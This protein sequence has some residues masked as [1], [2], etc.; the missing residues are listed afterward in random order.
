MALDVAVNTF[1]CKKLQPFRRPDQAME[2]AVNIAPSTTLSMGQVLAEVAASVNDVQTLTVTGTP[3][4]G[5]MVVTATNPVGGQVVTFTVAYNSTNA[6]AQTAARA[7]LGN[8]ITVT[9]GALP[10]T[11]LVFTASGAFVGLPMAPMTV[12]AAGLTGGT[13]PAASFAHTTQGATAGTFAAY[14]SAV[15][16]PPAAPTVAGN[17]SGSSYAA[18]TYAVQVTFL[19]ASGE[20]TPSPVTNVTVTAAQNLRVSAYSSVA[21]GITGANFYVNGTWEATTA[22]SSGNIPQT[23]L[24]GAAIGTGQE[25]PS[26]NT[27]YTAASGLQTARGLLAYDVATDSAGMITLGTSSTGGPF[28]QKT[29]NVSM[30]TKGAFWTGDL[31]GI[32]AKA[33]SDLGKLVSGTTSAGELHIA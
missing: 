8:N 5:S 2:E 6:Q 16:A 31:V 30:Y 20:T 7:V 9:G 19:T 18:G 17:G 32:D 3:T 1:T 24:T 12:N 29:R 14:S 15:V 33:I 28:G 22:I 27:A 21:S 13:N 11:A 4:G 10:G 23:D 26:T 25:P